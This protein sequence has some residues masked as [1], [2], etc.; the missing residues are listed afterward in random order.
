[1]TQNPTIAIVGSGPAGCYLAQ[2]LRKLLPEAQ[3]S[4]FERLVSPFGLVRY[5]VAPDHQST[6]SV[7]AQFERLF[8]RGGADFIG[9]VEIGVDLSLEALQASHT[10]V[11][12]A[13]GL[14]T[15]RRLGVDGEDLRNVHR[16]GQIT[17]LINAHPLETVPFPEIG[18]SLG[19]IG[20]GNV[21]IDIVRLL[22]KQTSDFAGSDVDDEVLEAYNCEPVTTIYWICRAPIDR[23]PMDPAML[24]E[25]K[26]IDGVNVSCADDISVED[27]AD[28]AVRARAEAIKQ[29]NEKP[30]GPEDR[31][32]V[33]LLL[34]WQTVEL[35]GDA[36]VTAARVE[37][38]GVDRELPVDSIITAIG[39][40][41]AETDGLGAGPLEVDDKSGQIRPGLFRTGWL[42]RGS[43]GTIAENRKCAKTVA[44]AVASELEGFAGDDKRGIESLP[45]S[46]LSKAVTYADWTR[47]SAQEKEAA[48]PDRMRRKI[49]THEEMLAAVRDF[50]DS[51]N[52]AK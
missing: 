19:V 43:K 41:F 5:G 21:S 44:A 25:L 28:R 10:I 49:R 17:R 13:T 52:H 1:M 46:S 22:A 18:R 36:E 42:R 40:G 45:P 7:Q 38:N 14:Y 33:E 29:L 20:G 32:H 34:G 8:E 6:K 48:G 23:L 9:N 3:I 37:Q 11:V 31:V 50:A 39:F 24:I 47:L 15:D 4:I 26:S 2:S 16:S 27:D 12:L 30:A 35:L 51:N